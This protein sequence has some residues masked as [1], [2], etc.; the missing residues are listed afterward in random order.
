MDSR[1]L[2]QVA[3]RAMA[4]PE[5]VIPQRLKRQGCRNGH[6]GWDEAKAE[7]VFGARADEPRRRNTL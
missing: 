3:V 5:R 6:F 4:G 7:L 1:D 2:P